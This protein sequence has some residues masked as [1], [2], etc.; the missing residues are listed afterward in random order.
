MD[1]LEAIAE[2]KGGSGRKVP[3]ARAALILRAICS[4][5]RLSALVG[6]IR[7]F[8]RRPNIYSDDSLKDARAEVVGVEEPPFLVGEHERLVGIDVGP[9]CGSGQDQFVAYGCLFSGEFPSGRKIEDYSRTGALIKKQTSR[10]S[11]VGVSMDPRI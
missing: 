9:L 10:R 1:R 5:C 8:L 11:R 4:A 6:P 3:S 2:E 7:F